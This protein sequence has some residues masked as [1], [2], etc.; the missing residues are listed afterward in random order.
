MLI[1][2]CLEF[3]VGDG[4]R[5]AS[6]RTLIHCLSPRL[7]V[8]G[9]GSLINVVEALDR[10]IGEELALAR[11]LFSFPPQAS[12]NFWCYF[13]TTSLICLDQHRTE[14]RSKLLCCRYSSRSRPQRIVFQHQ[15][16]DEDLQSGILNSKAFQLLCFARSGSR[17][18]GVL[19]ASWS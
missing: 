11:G 13:L 16:C 7:S 15:I 12:V 14:L 10:M 9:V 8:R 3:S 2:V 18:Y 4:G 19:S 6:F 17:G 1:K 5:Q